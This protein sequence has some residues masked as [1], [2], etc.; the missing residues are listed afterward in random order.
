MK[1]VAIVTAV[2][3]EEA[4]VNVLFEA[5]AQQSRP[6][7]EVIVAD[8]GSTDGTLEAIRLQASRVPFLVR[9]LSVSG[10]IAAGR[11]A[12]I[13]AAQSEIIA[14]T[15]GDCVPGA[16]WLSDLTAP[17]E[18][19]TARAA[20]GGYVA[21]AKSPLERA[22]ATFTWVPL[23]ESNT[24]FLPSHR[25]VAFER[26]LWREI[27]GYD[28]QID[29]GEDTLFDL[30]IEQTCGFARVPSAT[31]VWKPR[32]SIAKAIR[33]QFYY[34]GGD[35]QARIQRRYHAAIAA[36]VLLEL[37]MLAPFGWA[38]IAGALSYGAG[39]LHFVRKH[40]K[41]FGC[42]WPDIAPLAVL[43]TVLPAARLAGFAVGACGGSVRAMLHRS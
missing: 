35:G 7:D 14:V 1:T 31:V 29:S 20:A 23:D 43:L 38:R 12:A 6:P 13:E 42:T 15:D 33:Q 16:H 28:A 11:N 40:R 21:D 4:A 10:K 2:L 34:G 5:L 27:G 25:S 41:L 18:S 26:A 37:G 17:I 39:L 36:F 30:R 3:N 9:V 19:G 24:T 8:G 32:N 22:I